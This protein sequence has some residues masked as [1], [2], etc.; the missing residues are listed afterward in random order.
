MRSRYQY[1]VIGTLCVVLAFFLTDPD[2]RLIS[3]PFGATTVVMLMNIF[4][5]MLFSTAIFCTVKA[6]LDYPEADMK[7]MFAKALE[8]ST[9]AGLAAIAKA[10]IFI[11]FAIPFAFLTL[12]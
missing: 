5:G 1:L 12:K 9:G 11:A 3:L 6:F 7:N 4:R 2:L 8:T 10:L